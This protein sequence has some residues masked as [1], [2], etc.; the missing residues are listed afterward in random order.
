MDR[1]YA[2]AG[3]RWIRANAMRIRV[4]GNRA[5]NRLLPCVRKCVLN[6]PSQQVRREPGLRRPVQGHSAPRRSTGEPPNPH[7]TCASRRDGLRRRP[8]FARQLAEGMRLG[9]SGLQAAGREGQRGV[10]SPTTKA[11]SITTDFRLK[12]DARCARAASARRPARDRPAP[13]PACAAGSR[14]SR[15]RQAPPW[16]RLPP[17][18]AGRP[19]SRSPPPAPVRRASAAAAGLALQLRFP[20]MS[21]LSG[22]LVGASPE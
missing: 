1:G 21:C 4:S 5:E 3:A 9:T 19:H 16:P 6:R 14:P 10:G 15:G 11:S 13:D 20:I 7:E 22:G 18:C 2:C 8:C 12:Q 17:H